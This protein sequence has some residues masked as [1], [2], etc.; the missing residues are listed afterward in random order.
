MN[1][2]EREVAK[3]REWCLCFCI[4]EIFFSSGFKIG[5]VEFIVSSLKTELDSAKCNYLPK[6]LNTF[7]SYIH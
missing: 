1:C 5:L 7:Y 2:E 3:E 6:K 4:F